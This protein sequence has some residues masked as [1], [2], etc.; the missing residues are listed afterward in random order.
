M[1]QECKP[2]LSGYMYSVPIGYTLPVVF[3]HRDDSLHIIP[4]N[5]SNF[6]QD[7]I[8]I[9]TNLSSVICHGNI[10]LTHNNLCMV[11]F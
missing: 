11:T 1:E 10:T 6:L 9:K 2:L 7:E 8:S 5:I 3:S 4:R